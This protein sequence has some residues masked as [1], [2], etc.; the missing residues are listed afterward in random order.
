M[1]SE[2]ITLKQAREM[3]QLDRFA[4]EHPSQGDADRF[5]RLMDFMAHG[6]EPEKPKKAKASG[7]P[8]A[9]RRT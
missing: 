1:A 9:K 2:K 8:I 6:E 7:R 4:R 5:D 3:K